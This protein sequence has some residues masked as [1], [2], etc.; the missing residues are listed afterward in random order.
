MADAS[1]KIDNGRRFNFFESFWKQ[2]QLIDSMELRGRYV[3]AM[4]EKAF[5]GKDTE[6]DDPML[7]FGWTVIGPWVEESVKINGRNR[8]NGAKGGR[9]RSRGRQKQAAATDGKG[10]EGA[11]GDGKSDVAV[12]TVPVID[13]DNPMP[14]I[15]TEARANGPD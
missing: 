14:M 3:T 13:P 2:M 5:D 10:R 6:F 4:C 1:T 8:A 9:P 12:P 11:D 15:V 7:Q